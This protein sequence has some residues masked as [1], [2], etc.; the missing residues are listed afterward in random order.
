MRLRVLGRLVMLEK[1]STLVL[2]GAV[3]LVGGLLLPSTASA[4]ETA[5]VS[6]T[7]PLTITNFTNQSALV[8]PRFNTSL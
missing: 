4:L 3:A 7:V 2:A 1:R 8:F 5:S 6:K